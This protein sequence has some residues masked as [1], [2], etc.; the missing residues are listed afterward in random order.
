MGDR[1]ISDHGDDK[2]GKREGTKFLTILPTL[3]TFQTPFYS[4][5]E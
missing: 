1:P 5:E 3:H 4:R 2:D